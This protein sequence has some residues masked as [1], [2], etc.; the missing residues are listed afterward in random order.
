MGA[1]PYHGH[2]G[3]FPTPHQ[4]FHQTQSSPPGF[5]N[6]FHYGPNPFSGF[7]PQM[8]MG[9][10][11]FGGPTTPG[12]FPPTTLPI[13]VAKEPQKFKLPKDWDG[14]TS[15]WPLFKHKTEMA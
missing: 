15:K 1:P 3:Q 10:Y 12:S 8:P 14:S 7:Q 6:Q 5:S 9:S 2:L 13:Y 11:G 4:G